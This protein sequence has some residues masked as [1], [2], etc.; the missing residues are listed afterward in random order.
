V[1]HAAQRVSQLEDGLSLFGHI[2]ERNLE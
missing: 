1:A 2:S